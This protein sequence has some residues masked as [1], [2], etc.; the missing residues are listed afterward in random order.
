MNNDFVKSAFFIKGLGITAEVLK[1]SD[2]PIRNE[3]KLHL[4][5]IINDCNNFEKFLKK[6]IGEENYVIQ[7]N[8]YSALIDL[9][10]IF[11]DSDE[12]TREDFV[13]HI[14]DFK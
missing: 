5:R 3:V 4:N 14:K 2:K 7:D 11:L 12:K 8:V 10:W 9:I 6:E 1:F 13:E